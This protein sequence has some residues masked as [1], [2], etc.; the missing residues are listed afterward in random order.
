[1][2]KIHLEPEQ[3]RSIIQR[4]SADADNIFDS[5][6]DLR[7]TSNRLSVDWIGTR[8]STFSNDSRNLIIKCEG[9]IQELTTLLGRAQREVDEW[10]SLDNQAAS[11]YRN[12]GKLISKNESKRI[13]NDMMDDENGDKGQVYLADIDKY[14]PLNIPDQYDQ[15]GG[16]CV[17]YGLIHL[18]Y[19]HGITLTQEQ[20]DALIAKYRPWWYPESA[21]IA[22]FLIPSIMKDLGIDCNQES[23]N[24]FQS[25][26]SDIRSGG[27]G[28]T[29][30]I[31]TMQDKLVEHL[32]NGEAVYVMTD[33]EVFGYADGGGGHAYTIIGVNVDSSGKLISVIADTNWDSP[34]PMTIDGDAFLSDWTQKGCTMITVKE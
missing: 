30:D 7:R 18:A 24:I 5:L 25:T 14:D 9:K 8:S 26:E 33:A 22:T 17:L 3:V 16:N 21:G 13:L 28:W 15:K 10:E 20:I 27:E 34:N 12:T 32:K 29:Y 19:M 31:S 4:L 6:N 11:D 1:M 23:L 2:A